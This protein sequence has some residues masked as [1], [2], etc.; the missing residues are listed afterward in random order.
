[1]VVTGLF[2]V[3]QRS[4][5]IISSARAHPTTGQILSSIACD[6]GCDTTLSSTGQA[7]ASLA[8]VPAG[9]GTLGC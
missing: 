3:I 4:A 9:I 7:D 6:C 1:M 8:E 2:N 5:C